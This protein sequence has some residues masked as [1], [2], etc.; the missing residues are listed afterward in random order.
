VYKSTHQHHQHFSSS[1]SMEDVF[2]LS[3]QLSLTF[4]EQP[5]LSTSLTCHVAGSPKFYGL[6]LCTR[7]SQ[8][9]SPLGRL[10]ADFLSCISKSLI[11]V[12]LIHNQEH[13]WEMGWIINEK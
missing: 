11:F 12:S 9:F 5:F 13:A 4:F 2:F 10:F 3:S 8:S 1:A 6:K 7:L